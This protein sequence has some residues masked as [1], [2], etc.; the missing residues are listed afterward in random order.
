MDDDSCVTSFCKD[1]ICFSNVFGSV[2]DE[3]LTDELL[4]VLLELLVLLVVPDLDEAVVPGSLTTFFPVPES[5]PAIWATLD[6][7]EICITESLLYI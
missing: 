6:V 3:L 4:L 2:D 1:W 5:F 7:D